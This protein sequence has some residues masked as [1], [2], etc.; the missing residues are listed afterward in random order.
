MACPALDSRPGL[1]SWVGL[2]EKNSG[3]VSGA[4]QD[5]NYVD[6]L[7]LPGDAVENLVAAVNPMPRRSL[8]DVRLDIEA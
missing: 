2:G 5:M 4:M 3:D 1:F 7:G 8:Y 6:A